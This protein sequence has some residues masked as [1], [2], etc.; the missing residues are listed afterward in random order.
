MKASLLTIAVCAALAVAG[1]GGS[2]GSS[3]ESTSTEKTKPTVEVPKGSPPKSLV[4]KEIEKG[5]GEEAK[6]GDE[7]TVQYVGVD[8]KNGKEFDSSWSRSEPFTFTLGSG[9]VIPGWEKGVEGMKV[10]G[11]RELIV[12]PELGY[13]K[14]GSPPAIGPSETLVFVIDLLEIG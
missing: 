2:S 14:A 13:G 5:S 7:V 11:R 9:Q 10:G 1:C 12:P 6:S 8:Y 4:V 3:S